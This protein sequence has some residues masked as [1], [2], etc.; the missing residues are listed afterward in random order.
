M[1]TK[2]ILHY[3]YFENKSD[4]CY[5]IDRSIN[6]TDITLNPLINFVKEHKPECVLYNY[7][8]EATVDWLVLCYDNGTF[9]I[10]DLF[11][12]FEKVLVENNCQFNVILGGYYP[13]IFKFFETNPSKNFKIHYWPTYLITHTYDGIKNS[14]LYPRGIDGDDSVKNCS[15]VKNFNKLYL[16]YNN[17]PRY[18]RCVMIDELYGQNLFNYGI[19]SWN[20]KINETDI[21]RELTGTIKSNYS[22]KYWSESHLFVDNYKSVDKGFVDEYSDMVLNSGCLFSLVGE[23]SM[24]APFVTEKTYRP[25]LIEQPFICYGAKGQN[26]EILKFGFELYDEV[27]DYDFDTNDSIFD[28]IDG[29]IKNL[30]RLKDSNYQEIYNLLSPKIKRNKERALDLMTNDPFNPYTEFYKKYKV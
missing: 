4:K 18:H 11:Y 24:E 14:L 5:L 16:N 26:K 12:E 29:V 19:N 28:R 3:F 13:E 22:F 25:I 15:I 30:N 23:S 1:F 20:V 17:K 10:Y 2:E 8:T 9:M 27:F 6:S 21:A 7:V